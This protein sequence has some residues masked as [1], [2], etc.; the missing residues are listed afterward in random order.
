MV[1]Q[2]QATFVK[3]SVAIALK[4][5]VF[6]TAAD[7]LVCRAGKVTAAALLPFFVQR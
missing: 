6:E 2:F 3:L 5:D 4:I 7:F 1:R